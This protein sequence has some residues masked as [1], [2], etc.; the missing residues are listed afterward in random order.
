M[1]WIAC[2][3]GKPL[4]GKCRTVRATPTFGKPFVVCGK[5]RAPGDIFCIEHRI[6][7]DEKQAVQEANDM[8]KRGSQD[9]RP[10]P[11]KE[12]PFCDRPD[13][14]SRDGSSRSPGQ[15]C[16]VLATMQ[17]S[18]PWVVEHGPNPV[19]RPSLSGRL[20]EIR[21]SLRALEVELRAAT[22]VSRDGAGDAPDPAW[23][24]LEGAAGGVVVVRK[25]LMDVEALMESAR[26]RG[27]EG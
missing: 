19:V 17:M 4:G 3:I 2:T 18:G 1:T 8:K 23:P 21:E 7:M 20:V 10:P 27:W 6:E 22:R 26:L 12:C 24:A 14:I 13:C 11:P 5:D 9:H 25:D 15:V 16:G